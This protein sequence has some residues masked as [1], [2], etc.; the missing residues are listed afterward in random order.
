MNYF[1]NFLLFILPFLWCSATA[2]TWSH[3]PDSL[4]LDNNSQVLTEP[5]LGGF[6]SA[7]LAQAD[8]NLDGKL[9]LLLLERHND[10]GFNLFVFERNQNKWLRSPELEFKS[11]KISD[12][13]R[14]M[15][16]N[17]DT[18]PDLITGTN[19][20]VMAHYG[21]YINGLLT[22]S[23]EP[24]EFKYQ[25]SSGFTIN[26]PYNIVNLPGFADFDQ[27][28]DIDIIAF[29]QQGK[30][31]GYYENRSVENN[32]HCD[33]IIMYKKTQCWGNICECDLV[34][35]EIELGYNEDFF[36]YYK[37][38]LERESQRSS[39]L[40][41]AASGSILVLD[42]DGDGDM[43]VLLGDD[44]AGNLVFLENEV[45]TP[46]FSGL[47]QDSII[48]VDYDFPSY[49][50]PVNVQ[51][52]PA[53]FEIDVNL[54]GKNDLV[55]SPFQN[56][57]CSLFSDTL[58]NTNNI[59]WYQNNSDVGFQLE[60]QSESIFGDTYFDFGEGTNLVAADLD[61]D[62]DQDLIAIGCFKFDGNTLDF[63]WPYFENQN[64]KYFQNGS[65]VWNTKNIR[66]DDPQPTIADI[67]NDGYPD[68]VLADA[69]GPIY[70]AINSKENLGGIIEYQIDT[71][72]FQTVQPYRS[73][74]HPLIHDI[75]GDGL[76]DVLLTLRSGQISY[77]EN[78]GTSLNYEF[79]LVT[80]FFGEIDL[81]NQSV[82]YQGAISIR[83]HNNQEEIWINDFSGN[84]YRYLLNN[85]SVTPLSLDEFDEVFELSEPNDALFWADIND[86][87][88]QEALIGKYRGGFE[89][90]SLEQNIPNST[91]E[92]VNSINVQFLDKK[93]FISDVKNP[94]I[95]NVYNTQGQ[96]LLTRRISPGNSNVYIPFDGV[97]IYSIANQKG[98]LLSIPK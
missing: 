75:S 16:V 52:F 91:P 97:L 19:Q 39:N 30:T 4:F 74:Q 46:G 42:E 62:G 89:I 66:I 23:N 22:F 96:L 14:I 70:G 55:I 37:V 15:Q 49:D 79:Q 12:F 85:E 60:F 2:Q 51:D 25:N 81:S 54:D 18:I 11:P 68:I 47:R 35:N 67:N 13:I 26:I 82:Q 20:R 3:L 98:K 7:Q 27:D 17:C 88:S 84:T 33:S 45:N 6:N 53:I 80:E 10:F 87:G 86:D 9:D 57:G 77:F 90:F 36:C 50:V 92:L 72:T 1:K 83:N 94:E 73:N 59:W 31:I 71:T 44:I 34:S 8:L 32:L 56:N 38:R 40:R 64:G 48:Q 29:E 76:P 28:G 65:I 95:L 21:E 58:Q 41:H 43:D 93:L 61:Q 5:M 24:V 78:I 63:S 69:K